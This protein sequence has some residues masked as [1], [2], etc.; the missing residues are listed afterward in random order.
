MR[1]AFPT[2]LHELFHAFLEKRRNL[3][4]EAVKGVEGLD[5]MT[6][7]EG[8]AY[9]L[10]PGIFHTEKPGDDPLAADVKRFEAAGS[11]LKDYYYRVNRFGLE[12]RPLLKAALDRKDGTLD[13]VIPKAVGAWRTLAD[14]AKKP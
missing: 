14:K 5:Y 12:L 9:A 6:L 7:N 3:I 4:E 11:T 10:S 13:E 8:L 2:L 1:D